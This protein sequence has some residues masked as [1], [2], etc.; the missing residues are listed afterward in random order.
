MSNS[1]AT[2]STVSRALKL[3]AATMSG[4]PASLAYSKSFRTWLFVARLPGIAFS[5]PRDRAAAHDREARG[6][7]LG[8][9]C[10][11]RLGRIRPR[12]VHVLEVDVANVTLLRH[13]ERLVEREFAQA[14]T[15]RRPALGA[16]EEQC[17]APLDWHLRQ[18][19]PLAATAVRNTSSHRVLRGRGSSAAYSTLENRGVGRRRVAGTGLGA[20]SL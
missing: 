17:S 6:L 18:Q 3:G 12:D 15:T 10:L 14:S 8:A 5:L 20:K 4:M 11:D 1:F 2:F 16:P 13:L 7:G 19:P 9:R